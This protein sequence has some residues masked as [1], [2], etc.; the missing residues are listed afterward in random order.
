MALYRETDPSIDG[1]FRR[2]VAYVVFPSERL[3]PSYSEYGMNAGGPIASEATD[4]PQDVYV[5]PP[6]KVR[7]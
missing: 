5:P 3:R 1:F 7:A 6:L 4:W 2:S